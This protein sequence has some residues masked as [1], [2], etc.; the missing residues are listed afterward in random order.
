MIA[1]A[2]EII[3]NLEVAPASL[4][5]KIAVVLYDA[6]GAQVTLEMSSDFTKARRLVSQPTFGGYVHDLQTEV[7]A[8]RA[9]DSLESSRTEGAPLPFE[10]IVFFG[11]SKPTAGDDGDRLTRAGLVMKN[12][13]AALLAGCP[14]DQSL[15]HCRSVRQI[16]EATNYGEPSRRAALADRS[17]ALI[18]AL[19]DGVGDI[20]AVVVTHTVPAPVRILAGS[21]VPPPEERLG[22]RGE[23]ELVWRWTPIDADG[24]FSVSY[25]LEPIAPALVLI[26]TSVVITDMLGEARTIDDT[27]GP[28]M[29]HEGCATPTPE[30]TSSPSPVPTATVASTGTATPIAVAIFLPIALAE[31]CTPDNF[32][33]DTMLVLDASLSMLEEVRPGYTKRVAA[34]DAARR[35]I[36]LLKSSDQ[37]GI[38]WFNT[39]AAREQVLTRDKAALRSAID[40]IVNAQ[41]TRLDLGIKVARDELVSDHHVPGNRSVLILLTDGKANP[42]PVETA[43]HEAQLAKG[44]GITLFVIGLGRAEDLDDDALRQIASRPEYYYQTTDASTLTTIYEE[45][46]GVIP[47]PPELF[48]G[49]R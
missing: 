21:A 4:A 35:F 10:M 48:W 11:Y 22:R 12:S 44:A 23:T 3:A 5:A 41:F 7:A 49:R 47:C 20:A 36:D 32:Y 39:T 1:V 38:V 43:L 19:F 14:N 18:D 17:H 26:T 37:A 9:V 27:L 40:R 31:H 33:A 34:A 2:R 29:I 42:E 24:V 16:V 45:I 30:T 46:A 15:D 8:R 6:D 13:G 28:V 25:E